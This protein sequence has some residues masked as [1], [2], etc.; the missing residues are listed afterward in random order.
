MTY[1]LRLIVGTLLW[2][3]YGAF[4]WLICEWTQPR[5]A[6]A[7]MAILASVTYFLLLTLLFFLPKKP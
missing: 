3:I 5:T 7:I 4:I 2:I 1:K 6:L